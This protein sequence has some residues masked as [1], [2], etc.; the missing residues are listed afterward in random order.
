MALVEWLRT[1]ACLAWRAAALRDGL[2]QLHDGSRVGVQA[3]LAAAATIAAAVGVDREPG[4]R[5]R[6]K[7]AGRGVD[8]RVLRAAGLEAGYPTARLSR[9]RTGRASAVGSRGHRC[10]GRRPCGRAGA[11]PG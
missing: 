5:G 9:R 7:D 3:A 6:W 8:R 4:R 2:P 10:R 11:R 1:R